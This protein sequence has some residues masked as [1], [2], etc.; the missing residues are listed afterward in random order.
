MA[1]GG[2]RGATATATRPAR[3]S[4]SASRGRGG[5]AK[6][7]RG[8]A[9]PRVDRDG[10]LVMDPTAAAN[11]NKSG[12][13]FSKPSKP[14]SGPARRNTPRTGPVASTAKLQQ[15]L[16][17]QIGGDTSRL[18]NGPRAT[19]SQANTTTIKIFGLKASKAAT[20][21][22]G[23]VKSLLEFLER[24]ASGL[25]NHT[26]TIKKSL[27][28]GDFVYVLASN[29]DSEE[30]LKLNTFSFAGTNLNIT[31]NEDGWPQRIERQTGS[32]MSEA[33]KQ[34]KQ[35]LQG[36]LE[37]RYDMNAKLLNLSALGQDPTLME[38]GLFQDKGLAEKTFKVLMAICQDLFKS[39]KEKREAIQSVSLANN[40]IDFVGQIFELAD[41]FPD[42]KH[43]DLSG[44]QFQHTKQLQRWRG[45]FKHLETLLLLGNPIIEA[46]PGHANDFMSWFPKL[47][48]LNGAIVRTPEQIAAAEAAMQAKPIPQNGTDFRDVAGL[49]EQFIRQFIPMYDSDRAALA[50]AF[51]DEE[52]RFT[53]AV[54]N[55][56]PRGE[57]DAPVLPWAPYLKFSR[58]HGKI[59]TVGARMQRYFVGVNFIQDLWKQLPATKHPDLVA[60]VNKYIIDCHGLPGLRDPTGQS[61]LGVDGMRS[62]SRTFTLGPAAPAAAISEEQQKDMMI[63]ELSN[64]TNM[65]LEYSKMCLDT[66]GW[67]FDRAV[68]V[69]EEKRAVL[70]PE[71]FKPTA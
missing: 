34:S 40:G 7:S 45:H 6:R 27:V 38:M 50:A 58:N 30:I 18:P 32:T 53:L 71:A 63:L 41:T 26:V 24:K 19:R 23:G 44:N 67:D 4:A 5:I 37:Q 59:T 29:E 2:P 14:P 65:T 3:G 12:S 22:D 42:L 52:T 61:N 20:N 47:Q 51:Y 60:E 35:R 54:S 69:F 46:E 13:G 49:G 9:A 16:L 17:R 31:K 43:L 56:T 21:P 68:A 55:H 15:N 10:D 70:G 33:A 66:A 48:N 62:F 8:G 25:S 39:A 28:I 57:Q 1:P 11:G 36:V 64:R